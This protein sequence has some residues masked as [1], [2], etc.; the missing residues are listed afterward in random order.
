MNNNSTSAVSEAVATLLSPS[1]IRSRAH[2]IL[3][4]A[5]QDKLTHWRFVAEPWDKVV[6][7][8]ADHILENYPTLNIPYH[9]RIRHFDAGDVERSKDFAQRI[10]GLSPEEQGTA[11]YDLIILSVL[12][13]AG[14]GPTWSY[15]EKETHTSY[16]RSEGLA[17]ASYRMF[18]DGLFSS[19]PSQPLRADASKLSTITVQDIA[20]GM[21]VTPENPMIGLE[22]RVV[23]LQSLG[24]SVLENPASFGDTER[25]GG[26][27]LSLWKKVDQQ[28][29]EATSIL[30]AVLMSLGSIWPGRFQMDDVNLGDVWKHSS[31]QTN[32]ATSGFLPFHKLSQWLTYSLLEPLEFAGVRV[33]GLD[34]L[35]GLAE[36]RNGGLFMDFGVLAFR[37]PKQAEVEHPTE[38]EL[39]VEWRALTVALLDRIA[40]D[41]RKRLDLSQEEFPLA[42]VLQGGTWSAGR[43]IA[44]TYRSDGRP[45]IAIERDGTVF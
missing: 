40:V 45:P 1:T 34:N 11:W 30:E 26:L 23:L 44:K 12:L 2:Q 16:G 20:D 8:V 3:E 13:D 15:Q 19:D 4:L 25:P 17:V 41:V 27:F 14:A 9:S 10:A 5:E 37:D 36:Y 33:N 28:Q 31:I 29:I 22:G 43:A 42:K 39:V 6:G 32:D 38:S 35:T 21:Q 18:V 24:K 7:F